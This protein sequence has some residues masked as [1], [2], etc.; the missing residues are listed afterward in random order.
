MSFAFLVLLHT[1]VRISRKGTN[2]PPNAYVTYNAPV[3]SSTTLRAWA[4]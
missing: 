4:V 2:L 3:T 1:S